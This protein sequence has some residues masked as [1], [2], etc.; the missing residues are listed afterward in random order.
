VDEG[1]N[2]PANYYRLQR[3]MPR[4][5]ANSKFLFEFGSKWLL[6]IDLV[7]LAAVPEKGYQSLSSK[8]G[9]IGV[10]LVTYSPF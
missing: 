3:E 5:N 7:T 2:N 6:S 9:G 4:K 1:R 10:N 8:P